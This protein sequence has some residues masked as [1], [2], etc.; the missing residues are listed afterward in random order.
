MKQN[1]SVF[2]NGQNLTKILLLCKKKKMLT[3]NDFFCQ[4]Q[5]EIKNQ[6]T[7]A[8]KESFYFLKK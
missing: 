1:V 2:T 5:A 7:F 4:D 6:L 8:I 3:K